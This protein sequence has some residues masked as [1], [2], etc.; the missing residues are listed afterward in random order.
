MCPRSCRGIMPSKLGMKALLTGLVRFY[1]S[2][3][4]IDDCCDTN[5]F[6]QKQKG[7][8]MKMKKIVSIL[9]IGCLLLMGSVETF[10]EDVL[11][12]GPSDGRESLLATN[13]G[14][15]VTV[16][17]IATWAAMDTA[18]FAAYDAIIVGDPHCEGNPAYLGVL[19][20]T[21][22]TWSAAITGNKVLVTLDVSLHAGAHPEADVLSTNAID[23]AATGGGTGLSYNSSCAYFGSPPGTPVAPLSELGSFLLT[24][25]AGNDVDVT[26][27]AHP[28]VVPLDDAEL[29]NWNASY[30]AVVT[31]YPLGWDEVA[32]TSVGP[33]EAVI[34]A[35]DGDPTIHVDIDVKFLSNPNAHSCK[36]KGNGVVP[37][38]IFG[39]AELDVSEIDISTLALERVD[40]V[41]GQVTPPKAGTGSIADRGD[42]DTDLGA[43]QGVIIDDVEQDYLNQ[44]S[45]DDLDVGFIKNDVTALIACDGLNRNGASATLRITGMLFNGTPIMSD[46]VDDIGVDQLVIKSK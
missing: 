32:T 35:M 17:D 9:P 27:P 10:A 42:P 30:H 40:A 31:S 4:V 33:A 26:D 41:G 11:V 23:Y 12:Y 29:S 39:S 28:V 22:A 36:L 1:Y 16:A 38:T 46:A 5:T 2:A 14:H 19:D 15:T 13:A 37:V 7:I 45:Y 6:F 24:G 8:L 21:K 25:D 43:D 44:D 18:D 20:G 34:I 3:V